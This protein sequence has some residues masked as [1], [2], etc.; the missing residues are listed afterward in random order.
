MQGSKVGWAL[1]SDIR[2]PAGGVTG[3]RTETQR[4]KTQR[5]SLQRLDVMLMFMSR[6]TAVSMV[7]DSVLT[8]RLCSE[9][10]MVTQKHGDSV[11][12]ATRCEPIAQIAFTFMTLEL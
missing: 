3:C 2:F 11:G 7:T 12:L 4:E 10:T 8:M 9:M 5:E 6:Q 1:C